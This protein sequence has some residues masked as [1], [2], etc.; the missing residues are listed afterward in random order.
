MVQ[1]KR[2]ELLIL[3]LAIRCAH[4][5]FQYGAT[6]T[7][8]HDSEHAENWDFVQT[9][10]PPPQLHGS[11]VVARHLFKTPSVCR[12]LTVGHT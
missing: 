1:Q 2:Y 6:P 12:S 4:T 11:C 5:V 7:L 9:Y 3:F 10:G 8:T